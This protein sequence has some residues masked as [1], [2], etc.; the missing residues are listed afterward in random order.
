MVWARQR[1][2]CS[3][4][5][6]GLQNGGVLGAAAWR[7]LQHVHQVGDEEV[8]LQRGHPLLGQDGGLA[9]HGAREGE[10]VGG[11]VVLQAPVGGGLSAR[12][13]A[14]AATG[15]PAE[16]RAALKSLG[17]LQCTGQPSAQVTLKEISLS[18]AFLPG[19]SHGQ[20]SLVGYSL[21]GH[22]ESDT[23]EKL[24]FSLVSFCLVLFPRALPHKQSVVHGG[25]RWPH[26]GPWKK[27]RLKLT[28]PTPGLMSQTP[29]QSV[30]PFE[31]KKHW[32]RVPGMAFTNLWNFTQIGRN[33]SLFVLVSIE[34]LY[35]QDHKQTSDNKNIKVETLCLKW[36]CDTP[37]PLTSP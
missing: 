8:V 10:A 27:C 35:T 34:T 16:L 24:Q 12:W 9:A 33:M 30:C 11:D 19:K 15:C 26:Q 4:G 23:T 6:D 28:G 13:G 7:P 17:H 37:S 32:P 22:K 5:S 21:W 1:L 29:R 20:R 14:A 31:I 18:P 3:H 36:G 25:H 2:A